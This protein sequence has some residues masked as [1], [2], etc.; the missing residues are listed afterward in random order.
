MQSCARC[1]RFT[2]IDRDDADVWE[3]MRSEMTVAERAQEAETRAR[4]AGHPQLLSVED[5]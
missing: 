1:G 5:E 3:R 2:V 4:C